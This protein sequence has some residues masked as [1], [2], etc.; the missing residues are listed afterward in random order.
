MYREDASIVTAGALYYDVDSGSGR[1]IYDVT[2][3]G[4]RELTGR[5]DY[6]GQ[7]RYYYVNY[8]FGF[9]CDFCGDYHPNDGTPRREKVWITRITPLAPADPQEA[10]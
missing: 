3:S 7:G 1:G 5:C 10:P 9:A 2:A 4:L 8:G 6:C